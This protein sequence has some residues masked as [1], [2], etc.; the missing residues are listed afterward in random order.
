MP[1]L[2][3]PSLPSIYKRF[4]KTSTP[5]P[6]YEPPN[7]RSVTPKWPP[8]YRI[9]LSKS[10]SSLHHCTLAVATANL[11]GLEDWL[12][13]IQ[14]SST[15]ERV[16]DYRKRMSPRIVGTAIAAAGRRSPRPMRGSK[17]GEQ[18]WRSGARSTGT[19]MWRSCGLG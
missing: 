17:R 2:R 14:S 10:A 9:H 6:H 1:V 18:G 15:A 5:A 13:A 19:N 16:E 3:L 7:P 11:T 12:G 8:T 4:L